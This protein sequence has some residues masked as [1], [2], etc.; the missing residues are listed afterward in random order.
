[1]KLESALVSAEARSMKSRPLR[2]VAVVE[3]DRYIQEQGD[4]AEARV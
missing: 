3:I 1:M 4:D 2:I